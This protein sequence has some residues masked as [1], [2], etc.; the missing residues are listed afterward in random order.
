MTAIKGWDIPVTPRLRL[1]Q[2]A[3]DMLAHYEAIQHQRADLPYDIDGVVYKVDSLALQD[4]LGF[5]AK[6]PRWA[7]AH[8]FP[9][10]QAETT[11][12]AIDIQVGRTGALTPVARL[13]PVTV[14][15]VVVTNATLHNA[16]EIERL[17]VRPGSGAAGAFG[18]G[19][20]VS[21]RGNAAN[22]TRVELDGQGVQSAGGTDMNGGGG[23]R[24]AMMQAC[25]AD[26]QANCAGQTGRGARQCLQTNEAKLSEGCKAALAA[27]PAR[28]GNRGGAAPAGQ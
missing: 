13:T 17:G 4:R 22:L 12:E 8:K 28:G 19:V 23:G 2:S 18:E 25:G 14:G 16:D 5:V 10:E 6:A 3:A 24:G 26:I 9:A 7:I 21:V 20:S 15:G 27:M 1:C 11:L